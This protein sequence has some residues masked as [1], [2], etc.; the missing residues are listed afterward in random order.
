ML[1]S[2]H[3]LH[4]FSAYLTKLAIHSMHGL[5]QSLESQFVFMRGL[6]WARVCIDGRL[7][8]S[9]KEQSINRLNSSIAEFSN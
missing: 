1:F 5:G 7:Q 6:P 8:G 4:T 2:T 9:H 3:V